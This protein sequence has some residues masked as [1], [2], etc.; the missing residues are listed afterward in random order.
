VIEEQDEDEDTKQRREK[1]RRKAKGLE[2]EPLESLSAELQEAL[3]VED[4]LFVLMVRLR[5][6]QA[7]IARKTLTSLKSQGI[8]GRYIEY[9]SSYTPEDD[10]ERT[11]GAQFVVDAGLGKF[12]SLI[13]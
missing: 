2:K 13:S 10:F 7:R 4:L 1:M 12:T 6:T 5:S 11:Q 8:E 9:N 3:M